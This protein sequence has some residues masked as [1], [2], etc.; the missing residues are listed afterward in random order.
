MFETLSNLTLEI[1]PT[2]KLSKIARSATVHCVADGIDDAAILAYHYFA[3]I[4][5]ETTVVSHL[6]TGLVRLSLAETG[7]D[8]F[9]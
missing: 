5:V 4:V 7:A 3:Q 6:P 2:S 9:S 8:V 1:N